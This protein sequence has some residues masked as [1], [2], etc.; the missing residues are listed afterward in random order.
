MKSCSPIGHRDTK[1]K[2]DIPH[3]ACLKKNEMVMQQFKT[4]LVL[5]AIMQ[6]KEDK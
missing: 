6:Y 4:S 1:G 3:L 2:Q 5:P